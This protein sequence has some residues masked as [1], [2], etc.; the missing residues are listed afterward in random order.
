MTEKFGGRGNREQKRGIIPTPERIGEKSTV[1]RALERPG[2]LTEYHLTHSLER[3]ESSALLAMMFALLI[4]T[5]L[6]QAGKQ[7]AIEMDAGLLGLQNFSVNTIRQK[8]LEYGRP[9][10]ENDLE[11]LYKQF[12]VTDQQK[13][14][15]RTALAFDIPSILPNTTYG[16]ASGGQLDPYNLDFFSTFMAWTRAGRHVYSVDEKQTLEFVK[17]NVSFEDLSWNDIRIPH[18]SFMIEFKDDPIE[19]QLTGNKRLFL[20]AV[21]I[22]DV[23]P[24]EIE[25]RIFAYDPSCGKRSQQNSSISQSTRKGAT[26]FLKILHKTQSAQEDTS[27]TERLREIFSDD[28]SI[29][30]IVGAMD[31]YFANL[32]NDQNHVYTKYRYAPEFLFK[33]NK[34]QTISSTI[35]QS[36][37]PGLLAS[38]IAKLSLT[39]ADTHPKENSDTNIQRDSSLT[40]TKRNKQD[41]KDRG[42]ITRPEDV[43]EIRN[44]TSIQIG[45]LITKAISAKQR[46]SRNKMRGHI[47]KSHTRRHPYK[48]GV[49]I[50]VPESNVNGGPPEDSLAPGTAHILRMKEGSES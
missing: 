50:N 2:K 29:Q 48:P 11:T 15:A 36:Y 6:I 32:E 23:P 45:S 4:N 37:I 49:L 30:K 10:Q 39:I 44:I 3:F 22:T 33:F 46:E 7:P 43:C 27:M 35:D 31:T 26:Q 16:K 25:C 1:E 20:D 34:K 21:M 13:A 47:R 14:Q 8:I 40:Q 18:S 17:E 19:I 38:I 5:K 42:D 28:M 12:E 24:D 9:S 41:T